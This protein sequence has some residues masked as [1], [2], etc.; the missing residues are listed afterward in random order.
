MSRKSSAEVAASMTG[1]IHGLSGSLNVPMMEPK[2]SFSWEIKPEKA[3]LAAGL[4]K[5]F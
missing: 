3:V 2:V 4:R 1:L 5:G